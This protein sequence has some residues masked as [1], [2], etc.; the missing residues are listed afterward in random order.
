MKQ[1]IFLLA[2]LWLLL[3]SCNS[4]EPAPARNL[5]FD[6]LVQIE[7]DLPVGNFMD[8]SFANDSTGV[9]ITNGG[10][11]FRTTNGGKNWTKLESPTTKFLK[12]IQFSSNKRVGY[13]IGADNSGGVV[14]KSEDAGKTWQIVEES[15]AIEPLSISFPAESNA[16]MLE[17][18]KALWKIDHNL[19]SIIKYTLPDGVSGTSVNFRYGNEGVIAGSKGAYYTTQDGGKNWLPFKA[20]VDN[21]FHEIYFADNTPV[22]KGDTTIV[23]VNSKND[24][25][26]RKIPD[27]FK[28]YF[29]NQKQAIGVG[30]HYED[31][32]FFP[33]GDIYIT[34]DGWKNRETKT[35]GGS[36]AFK[37]TALAKMSENKFMIIGLGN[38]KSS[39]LILNTK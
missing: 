3:I 29:I 37:F 7:S 32:G 13:I 18:G 10:N 1:T 33:Y 30:M 8:L 24:Y 28:M 34:N 36:V 21:Q 16:Y 25:T 4:Q 9:A 27:V 20:S 17:G 5:S 19:K 14:L 12:S 31:M 2:T 26:I 35:F 39:V 38:L 15:A 22:L 6:K 11:I 23:Y